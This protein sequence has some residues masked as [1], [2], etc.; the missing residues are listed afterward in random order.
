MG[1][2]GIIYR[3]LLYRQLRT[4]VATRRVVRIWPLTPQTKSNIGWLGLLAVLTEH[5]LLAMASSEP[6]TG[7]STS[8]DARRTEC[9]QL[10]LTRTP[11]ITPFVGSPENSRRLRKPKAS[12]EKSKV[13]RVRTARLKTIMTMPMDIFYEVHA[14]FSRQ[15][16]S[17]SLSYRSSVGSCHSTY[18]T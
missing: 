2:F 18:C 1:T 15:Y 13:A 4:D 6:Y 14:H 12:T 16:R 11:V 10:A 7:T 3:C 17:C 5:S 9:L 8:D